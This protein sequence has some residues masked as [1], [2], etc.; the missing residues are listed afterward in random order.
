MTNDTQNKLIDEKDEFVESLNLTDEKIKEDLEKMRSIEGFPIGDVEDILELSDPPYYTAYPNPYIK[1]FIEYYGTPYDEE[2]DDYDVGPFVGDLKTSKNNMVYRLHSYHTKVPYEIVQ[3]L[4]EYYTD[5]GDIVFDG[6]SGTGMT[7]IAAQKSKRKGISVDLSSAAEFI[8]YNYNKKIN[9]D[10]FKNFVLKILEEIENEYSWLFKTKVD[11]QDKIVNFF[12]WS[13]NYSCPYCK[14]NFIYYNVAL[15]KDTGKIDNE[16]FCPNCNAKLEKKNCEVV[17]ENVY[18]DVLDKEIEIAKF[19]PVRLNYQTVGKSSEEKDLDKYDFEILEKIEKMHYSYW[20]PSYRMI[21]GRE[22]RRNDKIGITNTH[23]FYF[24]RTL[25]LLSILYEKIKKT[26]NIYLKF[27]FTSLLSR[28]YRSNRFMPKLNGSG[29]VGP[30]SGTLYLSQLQVERNPLEY[31][32]SKLND[33]VRV[34][35]DFM[36]MKNIFSTQ[37][38]TD[39]KNIPDNTVDYIFVDPPFGS[40]LMYSELNFLMESWL[41]VFTNNNNEA[42]INKSQQKEL[43]EYFELM[44]GCF[45][46]MLRILKPK[47]WISVEF[48]NSSA[49]VWKSI[50]NSLAKAGFIIGQ[51]AVLDKKKGTTK[52][53]TYSG[54]VKNDLIIHAYKPSVEFSEEFLRNNGVNLEMEF[55]R[56]HL[57]RLPIEDNDERTQDNLFSNYLAQYIQQGYEVRLDANTFYDSLKENFIE[58]NGFWFNDNQIKEYE[59]K[60]RLNINLG[61]ADLKQKILMITDENAAIIWITQFLSSPKT[62][63]EIYIQFS[64]NLRVTEDKLPELR[65]ILDENFITEDG[66][67]R[68][69][70]SM[71]K[72]EKEEV[73]N[74]RLLKEFDEIIETTQNSKKKIKE[75]RKEALAYGLMKLYKEKDIDTIKL[76][77]D[78]IDRKIIDS[79][80]NISTIID[81]AMY[82]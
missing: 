71:E 60:S 59:K 19:S 20:I 69:P 31:L 24:R 10:L 3:K 7:N 78:R 41:K 76:L 67:Y 12:V 65:V 53:L 17:F 27:Y 68:L 18:D 4:I 73:R 64:Q 14:T 43:I 6:F 61:E 35:K 58:I 34:K 45:K 21:Y 63:D 54:A 81:W 70:S 1:D 75:L 32:K 80:D 49:E 22:S 33:H 56:C 46:E 66:K 5:E 79:D 13:I 44:T 55:V 38:S 30:L 29:V 25:F 9:I 15:N 57:E 77:G 16:F 72:H 74:K 40:N 36:G 42:I 50:Q 62:F 23:Q 28:M 51:V 47:R 26:N 8:S 39:L 11:N 52:Q 37:S 48:H 2:T 82:K